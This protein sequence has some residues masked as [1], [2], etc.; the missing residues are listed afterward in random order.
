MKPFIPS[1][2]TAYREFEF[3]QQTIQRL[4]AEEDQLRQALKANEVAFKAACTRAHEA[5]IRLARSVMEADPRE[6]PD[7]NAWYYTVGP[8]WQVR[9]GERIFAI[10]PGYEQRWPDTFDEAVGLVSVTIVDLDRKGDR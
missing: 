1:V 3:Q 9:S 7:V 2:E 4:D 6:L 8:L 5:R 10:A